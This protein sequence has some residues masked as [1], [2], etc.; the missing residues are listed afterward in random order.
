MVHR[1][2]PRSRRHRGWWRLLWTA[3]LLAHAPA[4]VAAVSSALAAGAG[5]EAWSSIFLLSASHLFFLFEITFAPSFRLLTDRR[6]AVIFLLVVALLHVGIIQ[7]GLPELLN[8]H[9]PAFWLLLTAAGAIAW[10]DRWR[11]FARAIY[12]VLRDP[13][14]A[15][16]NFRRRRFATTIVHAPARR[17]PLSGWLRAPLRA[18]PPSPSA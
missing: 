5:R 17:P 10:R 14:E 4:T 12:A 1:I 7:H 6:S 18:P 11:A 16:W 9:D 3:V 13:G 2:S 15:R 8:A